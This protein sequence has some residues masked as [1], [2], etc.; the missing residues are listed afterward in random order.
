M[1]V[2]EMGR[3]WFG[4]VQ[5]DSFGIRKRFAS[6]HLPGTMPSLIDLLKVVVI[7][8]AISYA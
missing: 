1:L 4:S 7:T 3:S 8:G 5:G 2:S 6:F